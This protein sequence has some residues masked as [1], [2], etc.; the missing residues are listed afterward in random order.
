MLSPRM[1]ATS[2]ASVSIPE[3][4]RPRACKRRLILRRRAG[5]TSGDQ[6]G[7]PHDRNSHAHPG[8]RLCPGC[9]SRERHAEEVH[10]G[11]D[12]ELRND[13]G[14]DGRWREIAFRR[15]E[16]RETARRRRSQ[17]NR[18]GIAFDLEGISAACATSHPIINRRPSATLPSRSVGHHWTERIG[19]W[20]GVGAAAQRCRRRVTRN[21][22]HFSAPSSLFVASAYGRL[23][24][25]WA[26]RD[27]ASITAISAYWG[28]N[29]PLRPT[30]CA[31]A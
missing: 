2:S 27:A 14:R 19:G 16:G 7:Y 10:A 28:S 30:A 9:L 11:A 3:S 25:N 20:R 24:S 21:L 8:N 15:S 6:Q 31:V 17:R 29:T 22:G 4:P 26:T 13:Y 18:K 5:S 12:Q 1:I 23:R